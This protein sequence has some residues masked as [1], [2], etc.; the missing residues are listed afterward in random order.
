MGS[1]EDIYIIFLGWEEMCIHFPHMGGGAPPAV[2]SAIL[3]T[4]RVKIKQFS[5]SSHIPGSIWSA[6]LKHYEDQIYGS[7]V[8]FWFSSRIL[9]F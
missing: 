6:I 5:S 7:K 2:K 3:A 4:W 1:R 9:L 8:N